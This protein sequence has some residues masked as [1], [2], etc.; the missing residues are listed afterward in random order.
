MH[1]KARVKTRFSKAA[2][3]YDEHARV[4]KEMAQRL[5]AMLPEGNYDT[6][7][8][9]GCGTGY[10]TSLVKESLNPQNFYVNDIS[11]SMLKRCA[12][13]LS[14]YQDGITYV[15]GDLDTLSFDRRFNLIVS[16]ACLQWVPSLFLTLEKYRN[17][18]LKDG[19]MLYS[20]FGE[21]NLLELK[22]LTH[23]GLN[24]K[25]VAEV[26]N[27]LLGLFPKVTF[28][29]E[30]IV[31]HYESVMALLSSLRALG[32]TGLSGHI[33]TKKEILEL[34]REYEAHFCENASVYATWH[35]YYA[36]L[37]NERK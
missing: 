31:C 28:F 5:F 21:D 30:H 34:I 16:N 6:V 24:P 1:N 35:C 23:V 32:V 14:K 19:I 36:L 2:I 37:E 22:S 8:E 17:L 9:L 10:L 13:R 27:Y 29:E 18:L 33:W 20:G 4:Q 15:Q 12:L 3:T 26:R 25:P 11:E 7:L